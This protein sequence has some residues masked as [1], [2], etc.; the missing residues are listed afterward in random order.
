LGV[1]DGVVYGLGPFTGSILVNFG[2]VQDYACTV[3][4]GLCVAPFSA[5]MTPADY[6]T[7][8]LFDHDIPKEF[9]DDNGR[10]VAWWG[11]NSALAV[12][13]HSGYDW[14]MA[15]GT[16]VR[17]VAANA[18]RYERR[19]PEETTLYRVVREHLE[20]FLAQVEAGSTAS[21]PQFVKDEF[22]AATRSWWLI[23]AS[24]AA[25]APHA[26]RGAWRRPPPG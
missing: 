13:G 2:R 21:L 4:P 17:A 7:S 10:Y 12:D 23:R 5:P 8:N 24:G 6:D 22:G 25:F 16:P 19:R 9:I 18:V 14:R 20:T 11:E 3:L 1:A 26:G 15:V